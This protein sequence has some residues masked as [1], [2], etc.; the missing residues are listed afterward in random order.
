MGNMGFALGQT[1]N[2]M[3]VYLIHSALSDQS[4][5]KSDPIMMLDTETDPLINLLPVFHHG[6]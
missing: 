6:F 5:L 4:N 1:N 2:K 3:L